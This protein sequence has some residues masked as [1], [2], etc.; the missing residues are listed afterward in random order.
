MG[1]RVKRVPRDKGSAI[2]A[3]ALGLALA[4]PGVLLAGWVVLVL[5]NWRWAFGL[6]KWMLS[7]LPV[8]TPP[9]ELA[10]AAIN[11]PLLMPGIWASF[12]CLLG[13]T[14]L[15]AARINLRPASESHDGRGEIDIPAGGLRIGAPL[16]GRIR[17]RANAS[18]GDVFT[19]V[20]GCEPVLQRR[21]SSTVAYDFKVEQDVRLVRDA[22]GSSLPF[23]FDVPDLDRFSDPDHRRLYKWTLRMRSPG[24]WG[25]SRFELKLLGAARRR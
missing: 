8:K 10:S 16:Q 25:D 13:F 18:P 20:L 22:R 3:G 4:V 7:W 19:L 1:P 17:L 24:S 5:V 11:Y 9:A 2:V 6:M 21:G 12:L 14:F 23:H 15:Y